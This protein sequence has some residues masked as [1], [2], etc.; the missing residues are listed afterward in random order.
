MAKKCPQCE[1]CEECDELM[2][3]FADMMS[4]LMAFFILLL[5]MATFDPTKYGVV[6]EGMKEAF[7][8]IV[9]TS[10]EEP[11]VE[12]SQEEKDAKEAKK[13]P[14]AKAMAAVEEMVSER[15]VEQFV[16]V[17]ATP[18]GF[19]MEL[20]NNSLF[21]S[22]SA[23]L[24]RTIKPILTQLAQTIA[25]VDGANMEIQGHTDDDPISTVQFP[26]NWELSSIRAI[27]VLKFMTGHGMDPKRV[28]AVAYADSQPKVPN[29]D[30]RGRP[31]KENQAENRRVIIKVDKAVDFDDPSADDPAWMGRVKVKGGERIDKKKKK[32]R[33]K[34]RKRKSD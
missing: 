24:Q 25:A 27:N 13:N 22:G 17:T 12:E 3:T 23:T 31:I 19:E 16:K 30:K 33:R 26:S 6:S 9:T 18:G 20:A 21:T 1:A 7:A 32:K 34:R 8:R 4:L 5:S 28:K 10:I 29:R 15:G 11:L 14:A 2:A